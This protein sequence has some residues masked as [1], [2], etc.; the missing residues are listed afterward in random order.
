MMRIVDQ[1][2]LNMQFTNSLACS[3][4]RPMPCHPSKKGHK[5]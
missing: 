3:I 2:I 5:A 1:S 4:I